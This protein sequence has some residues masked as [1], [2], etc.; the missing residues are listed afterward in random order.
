MGQL[1][2][3]AE[4]TCWAGEELR[5]VRKRVVFRA[6]SIGRNL[7]FPF[8]FEFEADYSIWY[9]QEDEVLLENLSRC[10]PD[11]PWARL[12]YHKKLDHS[13]ID[14][15]ETEDDKLVARVEVRRTLL[16]RPEKGSMGSNVIRFADIPGLLLARELGRFARHLSRASRIPLEHSNTSEKDD[17]GPDVC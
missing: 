15:Y 9:S 10:R 5:E 6:F 11:I 14:I 16:G 17:R 4:E 1:F 2:R 13:G 3:F 12:V 8:S 7:G